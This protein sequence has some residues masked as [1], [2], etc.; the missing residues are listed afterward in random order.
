MFGLLG[1]TPEAARD[2]FGFLLEAFQ[3]GAPPHGGIAFGLDRAVMV[4]AGQETIREVIAFP[5]TQSAADLMT[6]APSP[7]ETDALEEAHIQL[8]LP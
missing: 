2:R 4:L 3:Y 8:K 1:I 6:G 7:V 5:K